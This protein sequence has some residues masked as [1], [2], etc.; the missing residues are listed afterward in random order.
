LSRFLMLVGWLILLVSRWLAVSGP[1]VI[2]WRAI[3]SMAVAVV[4]WVWFESTGSPSSWAI[5]RS[6]TSRGRGRLPTCVVRIRSVLRRIAYFKLDAGWPDAAG[7]ALIG[8]SSSVR[9]P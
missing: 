7:G 3:S 4:S 2:G 5:S 9:P 8:V 6:T 1:A